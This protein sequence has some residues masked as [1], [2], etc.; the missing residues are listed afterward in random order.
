MDSEKKNKVFIAEDDSDITELLKLYLE[1]A[2]YEVSAA[3]DGLVASQMIGEVEPDICIFDI[4]MPGMNGYELIRHVRRESDMPIIILSAKDQDTDKIL[5][6]DIGADDYVTKPFNPLEVVARVK[7]ALRRYPGRDSR[8]AETRLVQGPL[9]VDMESFRVLKNGEDIQLTPT[10]FRILAFLMKSPGRVYTK[11]QI[12]EAVN[13]EYFESDAG[14]L[15]VHI[16]KL[17][18]KLEDD[19]RNPQFLKT[20]RGIGY[21]FERP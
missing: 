2:G 4:M 5:G 3:P 10:E 9:E 7:A 12:Y 21:K 8:G 1:N 17:R 18:E 20:V 11:T 14:T 19:P 13:G 15:M 6:L 16:S